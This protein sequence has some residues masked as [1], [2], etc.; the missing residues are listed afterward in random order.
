[1][2]SS[3]P[4]ILDSRTAAHNIKVIGS[5][6]IRYSVKN[7]NLYKVILY[8][9]QQQIDHGYHDIIMENVQKMDEYF[10]QIKSYYQQGKL[11]STF[12]QH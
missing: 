5:Y 2:I 8:L 9:A 3:M 12:L 6:T 4:V 1:M 10:N 11:E 7:F